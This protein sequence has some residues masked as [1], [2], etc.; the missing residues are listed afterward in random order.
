MNDSYENTTPSETWKKSFKVDNWYARA[1]LSL[2]TRKFSLRSPAGCWHS[3]FNLSFS[4][5][6]CFSETSVSDK[7]NALISKAVPTRWKEL[8]F[9]LLFLFTS[10]AFGLDTGMAFCHCGMQNE[11]L[12][13]ASF[14]LPW[15]PACKACNAELNSSIGVAKAMALHPLR[16]N[17]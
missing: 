12:W 5:T 6:Q 9:Y 17:Q 14:R 7:C 8:F 11:G 10:V 16:F 4:L 13:R 1:E 15:E 3:I 2:R